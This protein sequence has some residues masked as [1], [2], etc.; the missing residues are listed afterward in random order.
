VL[1]KREEKSDLQ[2]LL[3]ESQKQLQAAQN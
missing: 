1:K 3:E 2:Q